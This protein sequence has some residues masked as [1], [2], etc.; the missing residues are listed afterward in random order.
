[1]IILQEIWSTT[2]WLITIVMLSPEL[3]RSIPMATFRPDLISRLL[4]KFLKI[5]RYLLGLNQIFFFQ[6][7]KIRLV[8]LNQAVGVLPVCFRNIFHFERFMTLYELVN[9]FETLPVS[10]GVILSNVKDKL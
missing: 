5:F 1:M 2:I 9:N 3:L 7:N 10:N 8:I 4:C 6:N